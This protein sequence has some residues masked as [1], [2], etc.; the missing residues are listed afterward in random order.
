[1]LRAAPTHFVSLDRENA[2]IV[3]RINLEVPLRILSFGNRFTQVICI[4]PADP[5]RGS[6]EIERLYAISH[7]QLVELHPYDAMPYMNFAE[8]RDTLWDAL[9]GERRKEVDRIRKGPAEA[10][11]EYELQKR[12]SL[13]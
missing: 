4:P 1:M 3:W 10:V 6:K 11:K 12:E 8:D 2:V 9:A 5:A 13:K 7:N